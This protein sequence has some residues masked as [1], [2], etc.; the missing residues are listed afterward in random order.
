MS[1]VDPRAAESRIMDLTESDS[2][3]AFVNTVINLKIEEFQE[4]LSNCAMKLCLLL[5]TTT[6]KSVVYAVNL[7]H[8]F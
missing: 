6:E 2:W 3:R 7:F 8:V 4:H 5:F 1:R